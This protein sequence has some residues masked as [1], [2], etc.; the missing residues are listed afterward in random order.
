M[1]GRRPQEGNWVLGKA[2][3][4]IGLDFVVVE[5]DCR[6]MG[7]SHQRQNHKCEHEDYGWW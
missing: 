6:D 3:V 1:D 4:P 7:A 2:L 5:S